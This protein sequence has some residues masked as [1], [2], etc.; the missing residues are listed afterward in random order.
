MEESEKKLSESSSGGVPVT[1]DDSRPACGPGCNCGAP[2][3]GGRLKMVISI[4]VM[5]AVA[6]ILAYKAFAIRRAGATG[7]AANYEMA[8]AFGSASQGSLDSF[9]DLNRYA[10]DKDAVFVFVPGKKGGNMSKASETAVL[11]AHKVLIKKG[12]KVGLFALKN[13]SPDYKGISSQIPVPAV[14]VVS[15]GRGMAVVSGEATED[16]ILQAYVTS[17]RASS[18]GTG[19][20]AGCALGACR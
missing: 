20:A 17:S 11:S 14:L 4:V 10:M 5:A 7:G 15:K 9:G 8:V 19:G 18:C 16:K 13:S 2:A 3:K 1:P 6:A 12:I